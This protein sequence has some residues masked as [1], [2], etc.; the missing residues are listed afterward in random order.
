MTVRANSLTDRV[1]VPESTAAPRTIRKPDRPRSSCSSADLL[2][3]AD[4]AAA[5]RGGRAQEARP[6]QHNRRRFRDRSDVGGQG[7]RAGRIVNG[8]GFVVYT[9][10]SN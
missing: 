1:T 6:Q 10:K 5:S 3:V 8:N 9:I 4:L 2:V 7:R